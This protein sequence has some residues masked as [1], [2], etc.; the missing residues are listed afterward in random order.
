MFS[1][2]RSEIDQ[3]VDRFEDVGIVFDHQN[4]MPFVDQCV[5]CKQEVA[6]VVEVKPGRRFVE[7]EEDPFRRAFQAQVVC[8]LEA[9]RLPPPTG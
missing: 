5:Q 9:L 6:N 2:A 1:T 4:R 7:N 3:P 8:Q